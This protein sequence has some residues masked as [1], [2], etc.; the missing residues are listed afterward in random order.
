LLHDALDLLGRLDVQGHRLLQEMRVELVKVGGK[1]HQKPA[2]KKIS[3]I[4]PGA[5][6]GESEAGDVLNLL[7]YVELDRHR[8]QQGDT[9]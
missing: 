3:P 8:L 9:H 5:H 7:S 1:V 4:T 6:H 2:H